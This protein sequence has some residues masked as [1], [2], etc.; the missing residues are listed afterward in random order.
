MFILNCHKLE[1]VK[2]I[3]ILLNLQ[4]QYIDNM[5][6][7]INNMT[8]FTRLFFF[9]N[10]LQFCVFYT[11]DSTRNIVFLPIF[12]IYLS[13]IIIFTTSFFV[14]NHIFILITHFRNQNTTQFHNQKMISIYL[15]VSINRRGIFIPLM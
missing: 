7:S 9:S 5:C 10:G 8:K 2:I 6:F 12:F 14:L 1:F 15:H 3:I 13:H 4:K 11:F